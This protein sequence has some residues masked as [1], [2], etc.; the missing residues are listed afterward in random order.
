[1]QDR[2]KEKVLP[3]KAD[4]S[5]WYH[6]LIRRTLVDQRVPMTGFLVYKPLGYELFLN[7][8]HILEDELAK[9]GHKKCYFPTLI[10]EHLLKRE[11]HHIAGFSNEV[12]WVTHGGESKLEEKAALRPTSETIMYEMLKL[13]IRSWRDLPLKIHQSCSV[14]RYETKHTR[15]LIRDREILWNEAHTNHA[16]AKEAAAQ[17]DVGIKIYSELF[18]RLAIPVIWID[19]VAGVFAGAEAAVEPYT[20]F[21]EGRVLE[22]GSVNN[23]GQRFSRVF[24]VK[25]KTEDGRD[26]YVYQTCYGVSERPLAAIVAVHGDDKGLVLPPEIAPT[27]A[28]IVPIPYEANKKKIL[29][30]ARALKEKLKGFRIELDDREQITPGEKF[31]EWEMAGVPVRI[32]IGPKDLEKGGATLVRRDTGKKE[33]VKTDKIAARLEQMFVEIFKN[34][35]DCAKRYHDSKIKAVKSIEDVKKAVTSDMLAQLAWCGELECAAK[36]EKAVDTPFI[37][38]DHYQTTKGKCV[39]CGKPAKFLG[40]VGKMY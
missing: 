10:P 34:M 24:D 33:F 20:I 32:E 11:E 35:T 29:N 1:M 17:I 23:L 4:F 30:G 38:K 5:A 12:F 14:F 7:C 26:E 8:M 18:R 6:E 37:G 19:V 21:P 40:Y 16:T 27:Q 22:M 9:T 39:G 28:V 3:P 25:F 13:W 36:I 15:P 2:P 31:Y